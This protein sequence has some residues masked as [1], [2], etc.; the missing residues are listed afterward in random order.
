MGRSWGRA[1]YPPAAT[2]R[3]GLGKG[4]IARLAHKLPRGDTRLSLHARKAALVA[5]CIALAAVGCG[6]SGD[7]A[8]GATVTVYA[9]APLC[10][11]AEREL[12]R[13]GAQAGDVRVRVSCLPK[14]ESDGRLDLVQIGANAR[15]TTE[16]SSS[17]AYIGERTEAASRFSAPILEAAD[18]IQYAQLSG[19][20][21]MRKLL[22]GLED[23]RVSPRGNL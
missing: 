21:A 15:R 16:D 23:G 13:A 19:E 2:R 5:A 3:C 4:A 12:A 1:G 7:V 20:A 6:E 9:V 10:A 8:S 18:V 22:T 14:A 17:I 11:E